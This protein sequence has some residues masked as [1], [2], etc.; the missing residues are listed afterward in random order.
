MKRFLPSSG[1]TDNC[2]VALWIETLLRKINL[3]YT[4]KISDVYYDSHDFMVIRTN[5]LKING[6]FSF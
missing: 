1:K 6:K 5:Y 2:Q 4:R 3:R